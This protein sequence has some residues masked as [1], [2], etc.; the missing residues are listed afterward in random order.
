MTPTSN[1]K[2]MTSPT[3][4]SKSVMRS[5]I[6]RTRSTADLRPADPRAIRSNN[7]AKANSPIPT[8]KP[9]DCWA[10]NPGNT[11]AINRKSHGANTTT[12]KAVAP[13]SGKANLP[14][15]GNAQLV[16]LIAALIHACISQ[17]DLTLNLAV[18]FY[19][20]LDH[21]RLL[22]AGCTVFSMPIMICT[23]KGQYLKRKLIAI[24]SHRSPS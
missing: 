21:I 10:A 16:S 23:T 14:R 12:M 5:L 7:I 1:G 6:F 24:S 3:L 22:A 13:T 8:T 4:L 15:T 19:S 17:I 11:T 9:A 18:S 2:M 20:R